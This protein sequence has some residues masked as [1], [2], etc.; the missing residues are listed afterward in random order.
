[1]PSGYLTPKPPLKSITKVALQKV[2]N[3]ERQK[4]SLPRFE[5][6]NDAPI[7]LNS[8]LSVFIPSCPLDLID[9]AMVNFYVDTDVDVELKNG[10]KTKVPGKVIHEEMTR[11]NKE[12]QRNI[13]SKQLIASSIIMLA[14]VATIWYLV[15]FDEDWKYVINIV[16]N[17]QFNI[18]SAVLSTMSICSLLFVKN[19]DIFEQFDLNSEKKENEKIHRTGS[20][21]TSLL[22]STGLQVSLNL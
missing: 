3:I 5:K 15:N 10:K 18:F 12:F 13:I 21:D 20:N 17:D 19:I 22:P 7:W 1:M 2:E 11:F 16:T 14:T 9:P 6:S 4:T 8:F